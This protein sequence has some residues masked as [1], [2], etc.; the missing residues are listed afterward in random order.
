MLA[1]AFSP[2][3]HTHCISTAISHAQSLC[4]DRGARLTP[5]RQRV[6]ELVWHSHQPIGAYEL[7]ARL[8]N[9]GFNSAPPTVYRALEFLSEQGLLH[10]LDSINAYVGCC[11]PDTPH[12]GHFLLCKVCNQAQELDSQYITLALKLSAE[13]HGFEIQSHTIEIVGTCQGCL[14]KSKIVAPNL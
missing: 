14:D 2:H 9:E 13:Q 11:N 5:V 12:Q 1:T 7:L 4:A 6:L 10:K 8:A 3:D